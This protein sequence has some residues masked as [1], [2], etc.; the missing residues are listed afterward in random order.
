MRTITQ[1][2]TFPFLTC[3][4]GVASFTLAVMMSP[5][6]ARNPRSPPRGRMHCSLRAPLLSATSRI[7]RIPIMILSPDS[8]YWPLPTG[9]WPLL[10]L[11]PGPW[12]LFPRDPFLRTGLNADRAQVGLHL[13]ALAQDVAQ[14]PALQL[15]H[16]PA[17][18]DAD[19]VADFGRVVFVVRVKTLALADD[20]FVQRMRHAACDF[21]HNHLGR[22]GGHD[23][24]DLFVLITYL[25]FAHVA[26][27]RFA[28]AA[29]LR[30]GLISAL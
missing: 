15:A 16:G 26:A 24:A 18:D 23:V 13:H 27:L 21:D 4:S 8:G 6:P 22:L 20:S 3:D 14:R 25:C 12:P 5:R 7:V 11:A 28:H 10:S 9:H 1:R 29:G 19:H 17:L 2:T 30:F